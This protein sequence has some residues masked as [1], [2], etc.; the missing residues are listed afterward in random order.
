MYFQVSHTILFDFVTLSPF[1][2]SHILV[3]CDHVTKSKKFLRLAS[4]VMLLSLSYTVFRWHLLNNKLDIHLLLFCLR[5]HSMT[6]I[7]TWD[8]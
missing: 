8:R 6:I 7:I 4:Y 2:V 3:K 5:L 1:V